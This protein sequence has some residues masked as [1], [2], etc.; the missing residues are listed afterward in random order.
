[1]TFFSTQVSKTEQQL[2][3]V[4][5]VSSRLPSARREDET[6]RERGGFWKLKKKALEILRDI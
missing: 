1:M 4:D 3:L 2:L 5:D 6:R